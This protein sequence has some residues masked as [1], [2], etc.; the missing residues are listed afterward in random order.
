[1]T[2]NY[3][4]A[5]IKS[6]NVELF[7]ALTPH[8]PGKWTL[9]SDPIALTPEF[10]AQLSPRYVFF[11]HWSARVPDE[12]T[13]AHECVCFHMTDV[14][15]GRGGTPLQNLI[16]A[17]HRFTRLSALRMVRDLDAGPVYM[18]RSLSLKGR[19]EE[20]YL[21]AATLAFDMM[22]EIIATDPIPRPQL[23]EVTVF[24]RRKPEQSRLPETGNIE[25]LF[26]HIRMLD[27]PGYP[28]AYIEHGDW[29]LDLS[30]AVMAGE[31][32]EARVRISSRVEAEEDEHA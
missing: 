10:L 14:P 27:A 3:V 23:G 5:T 9:V 32:L 12:V 4:V 21:R 1:M 25:G 17:G 31:R 13:Q 11:P 20:I 22:A 8:L 24:A 26:D 30:H 2:L 19:A 15:Y 16:T 7:D 18:K 29:R 28:H 6:W